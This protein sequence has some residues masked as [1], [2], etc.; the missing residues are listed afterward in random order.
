[1]SSV[2]PLHRKIILYAAYLLAISLFR[3]NITP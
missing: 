3:N 2:G 1:M